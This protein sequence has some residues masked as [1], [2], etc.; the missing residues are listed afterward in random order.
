[1]RS[2]I[3]SLVWLVACAG[4]APSSERT[5]NG[6]LYDPCLQEHDCMSMD[7]RNFA[8]DDFQVCSTACTAGDD[9]ACPATL[10]GKKVTCN[11]MGLCKPPSA[12]SCATP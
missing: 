10:D 4:D 3:P 9:S 8:G 11:A 6:N 5:C 2:L 7:C 12:N 1:M